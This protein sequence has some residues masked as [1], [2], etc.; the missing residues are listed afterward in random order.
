MLFANM[1]NTSLIFLL[2]KNNN[3][4]DMSVALKQKSEEGK[5]S[6]SWAFGFESPCMLTFFT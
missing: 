2:K 4:N 3:A 1:I 5:K 6:C